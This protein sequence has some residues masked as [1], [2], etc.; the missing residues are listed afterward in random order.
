[1]DWLLDILD[2]ALNM[3]DLVPTEVRA[4]RSKTLDRIGWW[5][6]LI[7]LAHWRRKR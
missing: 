6:D 2:F 7:T 3:I 4:A 1:M 5:L